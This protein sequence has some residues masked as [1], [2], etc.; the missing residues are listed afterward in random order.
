[1]KGVQLMRGLGESVA[2][3]RV[4]EGYERLVVLAGSKAAWR[5][6]ME[7]VS[8]NCFSTQLPPAVRRLLAE[9]VLPAANSKEQATRAGA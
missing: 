7:Y 9:L 5:N 4:A 8:A 2:F 6:F 1:M 3:V